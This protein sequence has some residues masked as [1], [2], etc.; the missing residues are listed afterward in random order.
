M[1]VVQCDSCLK[2]FIGQLCGNI[3][4]LYCNC[5][6]TQ[7]VWEQ[8]SNSNQFIQNVQPTGGRTVPTYPLRVYSEIP[9]TPSL[10]VSAKLTDHIR[11]SWFITTTHRRAKAHCANM[12]PGVR[13]TLWRATAN[14]YILSDGYRPPLLENPPSFTVGR[15][16]VACDYIPTRSNN[17]Y[18]T[19][20]L[21]K[22][23]SITTIN[24]WYTYIYMYINI[25][26]YIY[27]YTYIY[28][29]VYIYIHL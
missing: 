19:P 20:L 22:P 10:A 16:N 24:V 21:A 25:N 7:P 15:H 12:C 11:S 8:I 17:S 29:Y 23:L 27:T 1:S 5:D 2:I 18:K 4:Y 14:F 28:I 9:M 6:D 13:N 26:I 3:I